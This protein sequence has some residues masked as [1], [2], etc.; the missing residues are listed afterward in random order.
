MALTW[1]KWPAPLIKSIIHKT[2]CAGKWQY[3]AC[4]QQAPSPALQWDALSE[5]G[6]FA[7]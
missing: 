1:A 7:P 2:V 3:I 4:Q 6:L 5:N